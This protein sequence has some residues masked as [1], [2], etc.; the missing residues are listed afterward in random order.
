MQ[1]RMKTYRDHAKA[2]IYLLI[3]TLHI[4]VH[5]MQLSEGI[6]KLELHEDWGGQLDETGISG[7]QPKICYQWMAPLLALSFGFP[8]SDQRPS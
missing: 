1:R 4:E 3:I 6:L 8:E 5:V 7:E 2:I